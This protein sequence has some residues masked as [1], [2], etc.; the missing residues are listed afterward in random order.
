MKN[1]MRCLGIIA[2]VAIIGFSV[3]ACDNGTTGGGALNGTWRYSI[4][5][6]SVTVNINGS[7]GTITQT[8]GNPYFNVG[9]TYFR[10]LRQTGNSTWT[11][12]EMG[13]NYSTGITGY[14]DTTITLSANNQSFYSSA[15]GYTFTRR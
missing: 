6:A 13:V 2:L 8:N 5:N 9:N 10:N 12:E 15:F 1:T 14:R 7:N 4:S 3:I 11:G